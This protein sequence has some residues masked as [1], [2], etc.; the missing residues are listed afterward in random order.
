VTGSLYASNASRQWRKMP[1]FARYVGIDYSGT[2]TPDSQSGGPARLSGRGVAPPAEVQ[3]PLMSRKYWTRR[4]IAEWL[5]ERL[6][7]EA[8]TLGGY[9]PRLLVPIAVTSKRIALA[10]RSI[11]SSSSRLRRYGRRRN[12]S[13]SVPKTNTNRKRVA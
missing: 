8:P 10:C 2:Q 13:D 5:V 6:V 12:P 9:R 1:S 11:G 7:E 4:G 3:P